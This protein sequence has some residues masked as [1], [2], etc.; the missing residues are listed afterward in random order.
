MQP[1]LILAAHSDNPWPAAARNVSVVVTP[2]AKLVQG[3][4][5]LFDGS[6]SDIIA[7]SFSNST[8]TFTLEPIPCCTMHWVTFNVVWDGVGGIVNFTAE[9]DTIIEGV[10]CK[11]APTG[12]TKLPVNRQRQ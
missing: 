7:H 2:T 10:V 8:F 4:P 12:I 11:A 6:D 1:L 5:V 9:V 3:S